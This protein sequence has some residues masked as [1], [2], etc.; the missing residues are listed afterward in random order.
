MRP[1]AW[2]YLVCTTGSNGHANALI[3]FEI[4]TYVADVSVP[5]CEPVNWIE[6]SQDSIIFFMW[7]RAMLVDY[8]W[9]VAMLQYA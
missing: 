7:M 9:Q 4:P 2:I 1:S 3:S 8:I 6:G 5:R